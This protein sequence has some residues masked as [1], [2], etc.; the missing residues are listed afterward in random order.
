MKPVVIEQFHGISPRYAPGIRPGYAQEAANCVISDG[1]ISSMPD[2]EVVGLG[3]GDSLV[4]FGDEWLSGT[5]KHYC[6]WPKD[7]VDRL[8]FLDAG[9]PKK[10]I[11][12]VA[13]ELGQA[14]PSAPTV[15]KTQ[16]G[17][18]ICWESNV[19]IKRSDRVNEFYTGFYSPNLGTVGTNKFPVDY[20]N[21]IYVDGVL[22]AEGTL[23]QLDPGEWCYGTPAEGSTDAEIYIRF[24]D[25]I[26]TTT[27]DTKTVCIPSSQFKSIILSP[28]DG[29][30]AD[31]VRYAI[32]TI[33]NV[34]GEED[35]SGLGTVS[36][37]I[38]SDHEAVHIVRPAV[39]DPLVT[40]WT[41]Y[42]IGQLTGEFQK[43]VNLPIATTSYD[44]ELGNDELGDAPFTFYTSDQG[45]EILF[46]KPDT[47]TGL[48]G[49]H[50]GMLFGWKGSVLTWCEPGSPD[51]WPAYYTMNFPYEI[52]TAVSFGGSL[53]VLTAG[54]PFRVDG[55]HPELL[56]LSKGLGSEP[57]AG[58]CSIE[59]SKGVGYL[60]DSGLTLFNL[61]DSIV[62]SDAMVGEAWFKSNVTPTS[63]V[64]AENDGK[65]Y[66]FHSGGCLILDMTSGEQE[67]TSFDLVVT[68]AFKNR[69]DGDLYVIANGAVMRLFGGIGRQSFRYL[70]GD[71]IE[72]G[73]SDTAFYGVKVIGSGDLTLSLYVD[74]EFVRSRKLDFTMERGRIVRLRPEEAGRSLWFKIE[75]IGTVTEV[76][77]M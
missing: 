19:L 26:P 41:I 32:T 75:G 8:F 5:G 45:N 30:I 18:D 47:M 67:W 16:T 42:R 24:S 71:F 69:T 58:T 38:V 33:R 65:V 70:S 64:M 72:P 59:T 52:R 61:Y 35:E 55:S 54:G 63:A 74:E 53:A 13:A 48:S 11:S 50:L 22:F 20:V 1:K 57:C 4:Y 31:T 15:S 7:G 29:N 6:P 44:D 28:I 9:V 23:D 12:G 43:V 46:T 25:A 49:P 17:V 27:L 10:K 14:L 34:G 36:S 56:Q 2:H 66:L 51:A 76:T 37:E 73:S 60:S 21:N 3:S 39:S 62:V 68:A 40:S 77:V